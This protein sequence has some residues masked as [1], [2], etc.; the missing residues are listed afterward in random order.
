MLI[1]GCGDDLTADPALKQHDDG[2]VRPAAVRRRQTLTFSQ[3]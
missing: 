3:T 2:K 1:N